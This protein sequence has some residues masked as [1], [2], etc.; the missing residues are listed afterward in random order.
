MVRDLLDDLLDDL[1]FLAR[2]H[3]LAPVAVFLAA[4]QVVFLVAAAQGVRA[5]VRKQVDVPVAGATWGTLAAAALDGRDP[6]AHVD[7]VLGVL[8]GCLT[9]LN[10]AAAA[11]VVLNTLLLVVEQRRPAIGRARALGATRAEIRVQ[12]VALGA[13]LAAGLA[14]PAWLLALMAAAFFNHTNVLHIYISLG[15]EHLLA[16]AG[17]LGLAGLVGGLLPARAAAAVDPWDAMRPASAPTWRVGAQLGVVV[18]SF[19][20]AVLL[21]ALG[22]G[23]QEEVL[24]RVRE[25]PVADQHAFDVA[26]G[27]VQ[28]TMGT[29]RLL[30][31]VLPTLN[32]LGVVASVMELVAYARR[33]RTAVRRALGET[34]AALSRDFLTLG[35]RLCLLSWASGLGLAWLA[36]LYLGRHALPFAVEIPTWALLFSLGLS[37]LVG[38]ASAFGPARGA[39]ARDPAVLLGG[40]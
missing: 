5:E 2:R 23:V 15:P 18:A 12:H 8:V 40:R 22:T 11:V 9:L 38:L 26:Y 36:G 3:P 24:L 7:E 6:I 28:E 13:F 37:G 10:L 4:F 25:M 27:K 20:L 39:L 14:V 33:R 1:R 30:L 34:G 21:A 35:V 16:A 31:L 17:A 32:C 19:W 29:F